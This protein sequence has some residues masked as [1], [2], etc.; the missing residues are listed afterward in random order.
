MPFEFATANRI[1]FGPGTLQQVGALAKPLGNRALVI[2][3]QNAA[4][5]EPL[6]AQIGRAHV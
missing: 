1:L 4:R 2:T 6:L 3:G 5:A